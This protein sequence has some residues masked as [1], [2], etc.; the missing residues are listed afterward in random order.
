M[1][2]Y[3]LGAARLMGEIGEGEIRRMDGDTFLQI[4]DLV[5]TNE[6]ASFTTMGGHRIPITFGPAT[7]ALS[8]FLAGGGMLVIPLPGT[9]SKVTLSSP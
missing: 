8:H 6:G 5:I 7:G 9:F 1:N 4:K 2:D 3:E